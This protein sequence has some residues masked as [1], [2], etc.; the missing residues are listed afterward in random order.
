MRSVF[1]IAS[2]LFA[3]GVHAADHEVSI[4]TGTLSGEVMDD[5]FDPLSL[6]P[7]ERLSYHYEGP[8]VIYTFWAKHGPC[9]TTECDH[10]TPIMSTPVVAV[11]T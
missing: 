11:K 10:R 1:C 5:D 3:L 2:I 7:E 9:Q 6:N 4:D 8:E